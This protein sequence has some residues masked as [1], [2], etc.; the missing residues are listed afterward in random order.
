MVKLVAQIADA[1]AEGMLDQ[2]PMPI[3]PGQTQ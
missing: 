3:L 1:I 2:G